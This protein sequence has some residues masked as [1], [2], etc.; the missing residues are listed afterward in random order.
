MRAIMAE[1]SRDVLNGFEVGTDAHL[2]K[3]PDR[4]MDDRGAVMW[5]RVFRLIAERQSAPAP[6]MVA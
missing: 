6:V 3:Y 2:V 1:A 5:G 4:F